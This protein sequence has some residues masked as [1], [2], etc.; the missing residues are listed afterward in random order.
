MKSVISYVCVAAL[1]ATTGGHTGPSFRILDRT[2]LGVV[3]QPGRLISIAD[4]NHV[5]QEF[6][7]L[8][9]KVT[10]LPSDY[11][12]IYVRCVDQ[13]QRR[14]REANQTLDYTGTCD[15]LKLMEAWL[16]T[17]I[18]KLQMTRT[19]MVREMLM[20]IPHHNE[21]NR[22][23]RYGAVGGNL[24]GNLDYYLAGHARAIDVAQNAMDISI[25][26]GGQKK[27]RLALEAFVKLTD[28][29]FEEIA[30]K[31]GTLS[32][33]QKVLGD[34]QRQL[35]ENQ[36]HILKQV[37]T[38]TM[39]VVENFVY[40]FLSGELY[41]TKLGYALS[42]LNNV[43]S[44]AS[45]TT[46]LRHAI[47]FRI[48]P[49][50]IT[51]R[52]IAEAVDNTNQYLR[53]NY[54]RFR[55]AFTELTYYYSNLPVR[56]YQN[57]GNIYLR[58][59][60]PVVSEEHI[61][62]VYQIRVFPVPVKI[63]N[64][65]ADGVVIAQLPKEVAISQSGNYYIETPVVNW[66]SCTGDTIAMCPDIPH[67][68]KVTENGCVAALI[69]NDRTVIQ[70]ECEVE[71]IVRPLFPSLAILLE[72]GR[73]L[74][75]GPE[76]EGQLFCGS[77]PPAVIA[78]NHFS[79][80]TLGCDCAFLTAGSWLP[81]SLRGCGTKVI[82]SNITA[83]RN[84]LLDLG[85]EHTT[86]TTT[87]V[88]GRRLQVLATDPLPNDLRTRMEYKSKY[89]NSS[90][91]VNLKKLS[92][93]LTDEDWEISS[94]I[95]SYFN[96]RSLRS[97]AANYGSLSVVTIVIIITVLYCCCKHRSAMAGMTVVAGGVPAV[98]GDVEWGKTARGYN[99]ECATGIEHY[100][101]ILAGLIG[102][103]MITLVICGYLIRRIKKA[104]KYKMTDGVYL[105][106]ASQQVCETIHVGEVSMP[107]DHIFQ[108][109]GSEPLLREIH[110][111]TIYARHAARLQWART[112]Y[113]TETV[114]G[115]SAIPMSLPEC[116]RVSRDLAGVLGGNREG[117]VM[118][119][120]LRYTGGLATIVPMEMPMISSAGWS[121]VGDRD[122]EHHLITGEGAG[123]INS[124]AG[125]PLP[126]VHR[127]HSHH[128][129]SAQQGSGGGRM[130][131]K[132]SHQSVEIKG[133]NDDDSER[134]HKDVYMAL[135]P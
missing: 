14:Y 57:K 91:S 111:T 78:I 19:Q 4:A 10:E 26:R 85:M 118:A 43:N 104:K 28:A 66:G 45:L 3:M 36:D 55:V 31:L 122:I 99:P 69:R 63:R 72:N 96:S 114:S 134:A 44:I 37:N 58:I 5:A 94:E 131:R 86:W 30:M 53:T 120:L 100:D 62:A 103:L 11:T 115:A 105:Q 133:P 13:L 8:V 132:E 81:Y 33:T 77:K 56:C 47:N 106:V 130:G 25:N 24:I 125:R 60:I 90:V 135:Q 107:L 46:E 64:H 9:P 98:R 88:R 21:T 16:D 124:M 93:D 52:D 42:L 110:I 48:S 65:K 1:L 97:N 7:L 29:N 23:K 71:Y 51:P 61:F 109:K 92:K 74:I 89:K 76:E 32:E 54:P 75:S 2:E 82:A 38:N 102:M 49:R 41:R 121:A 70:R 39:S 17:I 15:N 79:I 20:P 87:V 116:V 6:V 68:R 126:A 18:D 80:I 119:R 112:L 35:R 123:E 113:A 67:M 84:E 73:I 108:R 127:H 117:V 128:R 59:S 22:Q 12:A 95:V 50:L 83:V 101:A 40:N 129:R 34:K 27:L